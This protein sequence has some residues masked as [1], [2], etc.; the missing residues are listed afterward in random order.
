MLSVGAGVGSWD[1]HGAGE[2]S[3]Y[4]AWQGSLLRSGRRL[5][6]SVREVRIG[7]REWGGIARLDPQGGCG[8][9]PLAEAKL[10]QF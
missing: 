3:E 9:C 8:S 7:L 5:G 1:G 6:A 2:I 4:L 10:A